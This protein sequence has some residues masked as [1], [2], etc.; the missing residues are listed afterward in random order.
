MAV[1]T[2]DDSRS[3][4][5]NG[6]GGSDARA[7]GVLDQLRNSYA[8]Q[9]AVVGLLVIAVAYVINTGIWPAIMAIWGTT[10]VL[11]GVGIHIAVTL[12]Q[13]GSRG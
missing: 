4:Q 2:D 3:N 10:V 8:L 13:R 5:L 1:D 9:A 7:S 12:S 6:T 11:V